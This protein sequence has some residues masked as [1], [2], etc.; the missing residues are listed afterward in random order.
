[1][2]KRVFQDSGTLALLLNTLLILV[3]AALLLLTAVLATLLLVSFDESYYEAHYVARERPDATGLPLSELMR[4]TEQLHEYLK[5]A[6]PSANLTVIA[7]DGTE[8]PLYS[9]REV[10]HLADVQ[11]LFL[12]AKKVLV[13]LGVSTSILLLT[14]LALDSSWALT[15]TA[16]ASFFAAGLLTLVGLVVAS[17]FSGWFTSFHEVFFSNDLWLLDPSKHKLIQMFPEPFFAATASRIAAVVM[18]VLVATGVLAAGAV[19]LLA[20]ARKRDEIFTI[21]S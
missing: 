16:W 15:V 17:G 7:L 1:L 18:A 6:A 4:A 21:S 14:L 8:S 9:E 11:G 20:P 5:G 2:K 19:L 10:L 3:L 12:L 13:L